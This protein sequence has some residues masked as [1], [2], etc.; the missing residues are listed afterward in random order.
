MIIFD[1]EANQE[2]ESDQGDF[3]L[4]PDLLEEEEADDW[5]ENPTFNSGISS[6][7]G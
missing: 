1:E 4:P 7:K 3:V 6:I 5:N 2:S